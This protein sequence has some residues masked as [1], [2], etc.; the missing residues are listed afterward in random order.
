M[1]TAGSPHPRHD[2]LLAVCHRPGQV[3]RRFI[4]FCGEP[5]RGRDDIDRTRTRLDLV[6]A[7]VRDTAEEMDEDAATSRSGGVDGT[8]REVDDAGGAARIGRRH[9]LAG[10]RDRRQDDP[11]TDQHQDDDDHRAETHPPARGRTRLAEVG[12]TRFGGG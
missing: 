4:G 11:D 6:E 10:R 9:R 8:G 1:A 2:D 5:A 3:E 7:G 12:G